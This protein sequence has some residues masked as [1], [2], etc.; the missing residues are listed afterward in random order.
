MNDIQLISSK[1]IIMITI[2]TLMLSLLAGAMLLL[3][4]VTFELVEK[5]SSKFALIIIAITIIFVFII[6]AICLRINSN[7]NQNKHELYRIKHSHSH[8]HH[9]AHVYRRH[10]RSSS[11]NKITSWIKG[12]LLGCGSFGKVY[13]ARRRRMSLDHSANL[14]FVVKQVELIKDNTG[15]NIFKEIEHQLNQYNMRYER[16]LNYHI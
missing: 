2:F 1:D 9:H 11:S 14:W 16:Y 13:M 8:L 15:N 6:V 4:I 5:E 12:D 3:L 10:R 7:F